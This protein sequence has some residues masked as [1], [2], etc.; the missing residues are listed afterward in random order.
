LFNDGCH[1]QN[2]KQ[3]NP[4]AYF[5]AVVTVFITLPMPPIQR[6]NVLAYMRAWGQSHNSNIL[7]RVS[8]E[9]SAT[10][11]VGPHG[12]AMGMEHEKNGASQAALIASRIFRTLVWVVVV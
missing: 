1:K 2:S 12:D 5:V 7:T 11:C 4:P 10:A 3:R 9:H 8:P 6:R